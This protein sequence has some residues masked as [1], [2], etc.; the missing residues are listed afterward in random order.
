VAELNVEAGGGLEDFKYYL[1][2]HITLDGDEHGPMATR[3]LVSLCGSDESHW[4]AA[5]QAAL[6]C[7]EARWGLWDGIC[8]V[9][10][11]GNGVPPVHEVE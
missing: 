7:L 2:R 8:D 3:L 10:R 4:Q 5:E 1:N 9:I 6:D 11:T